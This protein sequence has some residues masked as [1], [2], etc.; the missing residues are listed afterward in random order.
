MKQMHLGLHYV[1]NISDPIESWGESSE[2]WVSLFFID[3]SP[4]GRHERRGFAVNG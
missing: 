2:P 3:D 4:L 1:L